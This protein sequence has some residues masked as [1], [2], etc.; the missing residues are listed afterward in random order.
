MEDKKVVKNEKLK[1]PKEEYEVYY[2]NG[3][4]V[5]KEFIER[6]YDESLGVFEVKE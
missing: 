3:K 1:L 4:K 5:S 2:S 6:M